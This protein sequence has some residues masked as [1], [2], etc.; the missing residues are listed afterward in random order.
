MTKKN[1]VPAI[2]RMIEDRLVEISGHKTQSDVAKEVGFN[3]SNFMSII[4]KGQSKLPLNRVAAMAKALDMDVEALMTAALRQYYDEDT[5][6]T[7]RAVFSDA[8]TDTERDILKIARDS[9]DVKKNLSYSARQGLKD[10]F[11]GNT[12]ASE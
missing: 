7:L 5:V 10:V 2:A 4:K 9:M 6:N 8:E 1:E 11:H 3:N 12:P